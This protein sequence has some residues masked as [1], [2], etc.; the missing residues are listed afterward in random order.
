MFPFFNSTVTGWLVDL[1]MFIK[2]RTNFILCGAIKLL[3]E[4]K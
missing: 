2:N 4:R 3:N 1:G